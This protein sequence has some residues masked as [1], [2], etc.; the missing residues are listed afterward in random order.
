MAI[1]NN[2]SLITDSLVMYFDEDANNEVSKENVSLPLV[3]PEIKKV[4]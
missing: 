4:S 1:T 2:V 3:T